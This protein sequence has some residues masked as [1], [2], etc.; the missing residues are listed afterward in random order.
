MASLPNFNL[1][2]LKIQKVAHANINHS[3]PERAREFQDILRSYAFLDSQ[4]TCYQ[5]NNRKKRNVR[6]A[7]EEINRD[8]EKKL[9]NMT[10][11]DAWKMTK[12]FLEVCKVQFVSKEAYEARNEERATRDAQ[13]AELAKNDSLFSFKQGQI[14]FFIQAFYMFQFLHNEEHEETKVDLYAI[15]TDPGVIEEVVEREEK[16]GQNEKEGEEESSGEEE[17]EDSEQ[18]DSEQEDS[19]QEDSEDS[20]QEDDDYEASDSKEEEDEEEEEEQEEE[21]EEES[22]AEAIN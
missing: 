10:L 22:E 19:E 9:D 8:T 11:H 4:N 2:E 3:I 17:Q 13:I 15:M 16:Q 6:P 20:E 7:Q 1:L 14:N 18:E 12:A 21:E 5:N